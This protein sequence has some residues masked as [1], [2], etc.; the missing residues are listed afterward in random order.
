MSRELDL[1]EE[2]MLVLQKCLNDGVE[3]P[4]TL[5]KKL[6]PSLYATYDFKTLKDSKIPTI[7]YQGKR[8]E[9]A[10]LN[11]AS[12]FGGGS[13][14]QLERS[15]DG[16]KINRG[17]TQL[18]L[19]NESRR[20]DDANWQNLIVQGDNLQFLKTC[21]LN[22]DPII[23]DKVKGKVKLV[24]I[25]P[26]FATKSDFAA[27]YGEDS[28]ADRVD[29]A[30]FIE[31]LRERLIFMQEIIADDGTIYVHLDL[32]MSH[33]QK[34]VMDEIFDGGNFLNEIVW[35]RTY[36]HSDASRFGQIHDSLLMYR[37]SSRNIFN[38][39]YRD[40]T[41]SYI[42]SHYGQID[43]N[44]RR[45]R[46]V[47]LSAAG[48]GPA[49]RFGDKIIEPPKG[50]HWAWGQEKIDEGIDNG[51]IVFARTGQPNIKQYLDETEGTVV[52]S[53]WDDIPPV[54]PVSPE[55]LGYPTQKPEALLERIIL[56]SSSPG[57]LV[58]DVFAGSG[59]TASVAEKLGRRWI[60]CDFGKHATYIMQKRMCQIAD[61]QKLEAQGKKK[62][63]YDKAPKPFC[64]VSVGAFDFQKIMNLRQNRN[65]YISFVMGIFGLTERDDSLAKKY[66]ISN[67]C[68]LKEGNPVEVYP[69]WEDE[70]LKNIRVDEDYLKGI[71]DQSGGKL[72]GDYYIIA[73]ETC[74]RVGETEMRNS[75]GDRVTFK[76]LTFPYKVLEEAA[77]HFS[78]E[79]QPSS[80]ENIN[81][82][83]SSVGFYFN[84]EVRI[85]VRKTARGFNIAK[86]GTSILDREERLYEGLEGL[87]MILV[88]SEY[89]EERGFTVDLVIYQKDLKGEEAI[90]AGITPK[91]A[92]IAIDK[93]GNESEI[94]TIQ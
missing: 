70:F 20:E 55:L 64:V 26:P 28:Y 22:Q 14:L 34:I 59:T 85:E 57:D 67:V 2:D 30:E 24:Y 77:R 47:T 46:L 8:S 35:R 3:P 87:A 40:H 53:I 62:Q 65:A 88:D 76:L 82:L 25:D 91:T 33:F 93:H 52:Q 10:I 51:K 37:K 86:F 13:P 56:A 79:E 58:M 66:K 18:D 89:D 41:E 23:K 17:A 19:F 1:S 75:R 69:I 38:K 72:K 78:I 27:K 94:T 16:G 92:I 60:M 63:K 7:E 36:A 80:P 32:K 48:P 11:E 61:S 73:P 31:Q 6:F 43:Q 39:Q 4:Q 44:G 90:V 74:V 83:I 29:R 12:A 42:K 45:Y 9:A 21:Y 71:L 15:F 68:A 81:K 49:R 54:N 5:A 50:R 84:E